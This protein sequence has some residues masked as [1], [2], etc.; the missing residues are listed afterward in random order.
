MIDYYEILHV[1]Y[2]FTK[3][4]L[5]KNY[6]KLCL[7]YHPDKNN[8]VYEDKFKEINEAYEILSDDIKRKEY[9]IKQN[10]SFLDEFQ[11]TDEEIQ[12]LYK[13]YQNIIHSNEYKLCMLLVKSIPQ[14]IKEQLKQKFMKSNEF[15]KSN[16]LIKS[17]KWIDIQS[18]NEDFTIHLLI[19]KYDYE[20]NILKQ[21]NVHTKYG[22]YYL[23]LRCYKQTIYIDNLSNN[24]KIQLIH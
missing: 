18:L 8:R 14:S 1:K 20:N 2:D 10:L 23:F 11:F 3:E 6:Y 16:Q 21:I 5:K 22:I 9:D 17:P 13:Y 7:Q 4:E 12:L 15:M 24:F 19:S